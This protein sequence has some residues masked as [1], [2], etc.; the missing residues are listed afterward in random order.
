[1]IYNTQM[2]RAIRRAE[3]KR[4]SVPTRG[5]GGFVVAQVKKYLQKY[6]LLES[7]G[8]GVE[9]SIWSVPAA[10]NIGCRWIRM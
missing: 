6:S 5:S 8:V 10:G 4:V 2:S 1:M 7:A 9:D 3:S